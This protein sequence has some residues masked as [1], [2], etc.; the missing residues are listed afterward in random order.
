M[1]T[2][3]KEKTNEKPQPS[4]FSCVG[5]SLVAGAMASGCYFLTSSIAQNFANKP[6]HTANIAVANITVAVRTLVVG[7]C[8]L[9]SALFGIAALGLMALG[10]QILIQQLTKQPTTPPNSQT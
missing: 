4:V 9:G 5:G 2:N 6:I 8:A 1:T 7:M 3:D 10:V